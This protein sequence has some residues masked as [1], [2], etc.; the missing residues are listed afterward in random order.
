M[1]KHII[2]YVRHKTQNTHQTL[3][4]GKHSLHLRFHIGLC[5]FHVNS[6][7][8][9]WCVNFEV[10]E[11][12]K[13]SESVTKTSNQALASQFTLW[14]QKLQGHSVPAKPVQ[15]SPDSIK[16]VLPYHAR[17][18]PTISADSAAKNVNPIGPLKVC[19]GVQMESAHSAELEF[20][21]GHVILTYFDFNFCLS[22]VFDFN[23]K[24]ILL[25]GCSQP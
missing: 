25:S 7:T 1:H 14:Y 5:L 23:P 10:E 6:S 9:T 15:F 20:F 16:R 11:I 13:L 3:S 12:W 4:L 22:S 17:F 21:N 24:P 18:L 2:D 19:K 8:Q